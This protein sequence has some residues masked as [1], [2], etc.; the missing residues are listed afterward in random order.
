MK[1][2]PEL[3]MTL[4]VPLFTLARL[5]NKG[6]YEFYRARPAA[7]LALADSGHAAHTANTMCNTEWP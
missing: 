4:R 2:K 1:R 7:F 5:F 3:D 6:E